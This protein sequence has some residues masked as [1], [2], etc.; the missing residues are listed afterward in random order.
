MASR[1]SRRYKRRGVSISFGDIMLPFVGVVA[2][3]LLVVAGKLFFL[4]GIRPERSSPPVVREFS[5]HDPE[6]AHAEPPSHEWG[7]TPSPAPDAVP[8]R[9]GTFVPSASVPSTASSDRAFDGK[10]PDPHRPTISIDLFAVP[11]G[12]ETPNALKKG[13]SPSVSGEETPKKETPKK[14][15]PKKETP[16]KEA[17]KKEAP[18]KEAPKKDV[19]KEP[20]NKKEVSKK[21]VSKKEAPRE[22]SGGPQNVVRR[23]EVVVSPVPKPAKPPSPVVPKPAPKPGN[24]SWHVQ[25]GAFSSKE[26]AVE[27]SRKLSQSGYKVSV[28]SGVR[29]HRVVVQAGSS[30]QEALT[31][32]SRL[33]KEGFPDAFSIP[34]VSP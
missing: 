10:L 14:E 32:A 12:T 27:V 19:V 17:P 4:N 25:V 9:T 15:T 3:G 7:I 31:L 2:I 34:P 18:K 11:Y 23:V 33:Q 16:K 20:S 22:G 6:P 13:E 28:S 24:S 21:E 29:F 8:D 1:E 30:R 5:M 26:S